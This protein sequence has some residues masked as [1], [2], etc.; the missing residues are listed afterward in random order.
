MSK[1]D[2]IR[3]LEYLNDTKDLIKQAIINK[4]VEVDS[5]LPFR[6]YADKIGEISGGG[7]GVPN[8]E[9]INLYTSGSI[10]IGID[11]EGI[12]VEPYNTYVCALANK[13]DDST[14]TIPLGKTLRHYEINL[15]LQPFY[16]ESAYYGAICWR[17]LNE[18]GLYTDIKLNYINEKRR[19]IAKRTYN[20]NVGDTL[21]FKL[22]DPVL[23]KYT[24]ANG[25]TTVTFKTDDSNSVT[26]TYSA[27]VPLT[28][29]SINAMY[30]FGD[31]GDSSQSVN[32]RGVGKLY[33]EGTYIRDLD[34][35]EIVWELCDGYNK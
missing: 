28:M 2:I 25:N 14:L 4:G 12:M 21:K 26:T 24:F 13:Y 1:K 34:T 5:S 29:T 7:K 17:G 22:T 19:M 33:F 30:I 15:K 35:N 9:D 3:K 8:R 23:I 6:Q 16:Q 27:G 20:V 10:N 18:C 11:K 31:G 32:R